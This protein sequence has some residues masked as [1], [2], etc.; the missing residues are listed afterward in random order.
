MPG[1]DQDQLAQAEARLGTRL[2][3]KWRLDRVLGIGG[4]ATVY[5]ATHRNGKQAAIKVLRPEAALVSDIKARFL[6]EG[7][8]ANRVGHP[9]AVSI[10]D[11]DVDENGTVYLVMELLVGETLEQRWRDRGK[12]P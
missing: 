5:E 1:S 7:Y 2:R 9:G 10:L 6:R 4:M 12:L 3:D 8:L 11:D